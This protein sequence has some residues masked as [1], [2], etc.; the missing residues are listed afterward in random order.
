M[1]QDIV[2]VAVSNG[3]FALLFVAL[4]LYQ[5]K[6]SRNREKRYV[7]TIQRL[8]YHLDVVLEIKNAVEKIQN[9]VGKGE[10][11]HERKIK[12]KNQIV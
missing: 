12:T 10:T 9:E 4:L 6:D 2:N 11:K 3:L 8:T 1:W 5:L 7:Q